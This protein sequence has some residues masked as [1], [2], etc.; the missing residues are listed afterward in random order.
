[1]HPTVTGLVNSQTASVLGSGL[2]CTTA[3]GPTSL[4]GTYAS[5]CS[6]AVDANYAISYASGT[7]T[8]GP[9]A[10]KVT[11][12]NVTKMFGVA[13]P[14]LSA[15]I[16]GFVDGQTLATSGVTGQPVCTT[17]ATISSPNGTYPITCQVGTLHAANYTFTF[18]AGTLTVGYT[19]TVCDVFG[20]DRT[21]LLDSRH[22]HGQAGRCSRQRGSGAPRCGDRQWRRQPAHLQHQRGPHPVGV[23]FVGIDGGR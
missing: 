7:V 6:G 13:V 18:V 10:L 17:T 2:V 22:R 8:V 14:A 1:M 9:A 23:R 16:T 21:R 4:V 20:A 5:T 15:A 11:A 19:S 12:T 3:A